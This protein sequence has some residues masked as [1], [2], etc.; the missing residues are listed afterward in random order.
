MSILTDPIQNTPQL[1]FTVF[2]TSLSTAV[3]IR[4][5]AM[6]RMVARRRNATFW[7]GYVRYIRVSAIV[8]A[9]VQAVL[10]LNHLVSR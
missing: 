8:I 6:L 4:P 3:A 9:I 1:L 10:L 5:L 2:A 7:P